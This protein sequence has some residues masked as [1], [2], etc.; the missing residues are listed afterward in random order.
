MKFLLIGRRKTINTPF[1]LQNLSM[2]PGPIEAAYLKPRPS[3]A[4]FG[5]E[6]VELSQVD[7]VFRV[8][9]ILHP[10]LPDLGKFLQKLKLFYASRIALE[11][12]KSSCSLKN[13]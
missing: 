12:A 6:S 13:F 2:L 11:F 4:E 8:G 10:P 1:Y 3:E 9:Q 5:S 7:F